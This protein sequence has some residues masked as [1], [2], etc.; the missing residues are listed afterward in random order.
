MKVT[1]ADWRAYCSAALADAGVYA[2]CFSPA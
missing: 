1:M 2:A